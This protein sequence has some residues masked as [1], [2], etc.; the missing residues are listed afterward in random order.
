MFATPNQSGTSRLRTSRGVA[1][2][3]VLLVYLLAGALHGFCHLDVTTPTPGATVISMPVTA[4]SHDSGKTLAADHHCHG[5]FSVAV[6][7]PVMLAA[8]AEPV[9]SEPS[10][11]QSHV[12]SLARSIDTPPPK[13]LT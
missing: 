3:C 8:R 10:Q 12:A 6:P 4:D 9:V 11:P 5:C 2:L 7:A 1:A 13:Q